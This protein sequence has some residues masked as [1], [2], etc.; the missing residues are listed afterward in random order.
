VRQEENEKLPNEP[1]FSDPTQTAVNE[2]AADSL[3]EQGK[4]PNT[5]FRGE[6]DRA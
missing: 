4:Q 6:A 3:Q 2:L 1:N 5:S